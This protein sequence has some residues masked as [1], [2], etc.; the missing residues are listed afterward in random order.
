MSRLVLLVILFLW[1]APAGAE[2]SG[3]SLWLAA[4]DSAAQLV[5]VLRAWRPSG[6]KLEASPPVDLSEIFRR[7]EELH[8]NMWVLHPFP[9]IGIEFDEHEPLVRKI[10]RGGPAERAGIKPGDR[11]QVNG[12]DDIAAINDLTMHGPGPFQVIVAGRPPLSLKKDVPDY[13]PPD[14]AAEID[15]EFASVKQAAMELVKLSNESGTDREEVHDQTAQIYER[16]KKLEDRLKG[17]QEE[18][19]R[20]NGG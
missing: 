11:L 14:L 7:I 16:L 10:R 8:K 6:L 3:Q 18:S 19:D 17:I 15:A 1:A 20:R 5:D 9:N 2:E 13:P 12:V 4:Q